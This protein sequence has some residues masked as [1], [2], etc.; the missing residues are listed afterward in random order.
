[1]EACIFFRRDGVEYSIKVTVDFSDISVIKETFIDTER[2]SH[3]KDL[4][5]R[6]SIRQIIKS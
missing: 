3:E 4:W 5:I 2:E 1:M 6:Q